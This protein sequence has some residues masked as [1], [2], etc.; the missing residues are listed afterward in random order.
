MGLLDKTQILGGDGTTRGF[1]TAPHIYGELAAT[2]GK[3][4]C[5]RIRLFLDSI[6]HGEHYGRWY[7]GKITDPAKLLTKL[8][9]PGEIGP[10]TAIGHDYQLVEKA[11]VVN[12][13]PSWKSG[14]FVMEVVQEDTVR[15]CSRYSDSEISFIVWP[16][17]AWKR[18]ASS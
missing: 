1:L 16:N 5:D 9:D 2:H 8:V 11:G 13:K 6:R 14:Q 3:D 10:C 17:C 4:V 18:M 12:V 15:S 7:T